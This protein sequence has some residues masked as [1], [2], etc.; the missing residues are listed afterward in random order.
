[1]QAQ[2]KAI[3]L[4]AFDKKGNTDSTGKKWPSQRCYDIAFI[5]DRGSS[6]DTVKFNTDDE[7]N[8]QIIADLDKVQKTSQP[9]ILTGEFSKFKDG[10][11]RF[12]PQ[13]VGKAA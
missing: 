1:M 9:V 5:G 6:T 4:S 13:Q 8:D 3:V 10:P 7:R 2:S 11:W 12:R